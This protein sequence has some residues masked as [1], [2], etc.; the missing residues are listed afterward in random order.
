LD[1]PSVECVLNY[2]IPRDPTDY[3]HRVGRTARA[4]R[5]GKA[6][7]IVA[8]KDIQLVQNIEERTSKLPIDYI[9]EKRDDKLNA[10][11]L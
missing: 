4:G 2:D 9:E 11:F 1:I 3:I 8:E 7:S 6:I 10:L 5:G